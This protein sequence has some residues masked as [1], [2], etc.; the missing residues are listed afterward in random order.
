M[1]EGLLFGFEND[2]FICF[3][4]GSLLGDERNGNLLFE[5]LWIY[6]VY[7]WLLFFSL[8]IEFL[9]LSGVVII[10]NGVFCLFYFIE[11]EIYYF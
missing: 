11:G 6:F 4:F 10:F 7:V 5:Y 1:F 2:L 9:L 3:C 8:G